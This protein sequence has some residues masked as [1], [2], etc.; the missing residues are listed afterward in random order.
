MASTNDEDVERGFITDVTD[1]SRCKTSIY[2]EITHLLSRPD[3]FVSINKRE[4]RSVFD[5]E[6][7]KKVSK[8]I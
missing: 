2:K 4:E 8:G 5:L 3:R 6:L 1:Y 7:I